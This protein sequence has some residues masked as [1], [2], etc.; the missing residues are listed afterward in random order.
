MDSLIVAF[1]IRDLSPARV[2]LYL[3]W[4]SYS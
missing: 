2:T 3:H 4:K 1:N